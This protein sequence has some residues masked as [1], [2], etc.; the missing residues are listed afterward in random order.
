MQRHVN[1]ITPSKEESSIAEE[2]LTEPQNSTLEFAD[3]RPKIKQLKKLQE[4]INNSSRQ[5]T[6][7]Q[8][9]NKAQAYTNAKT[10]PVLQ[11]EN[12]T[13]LPTTLKTGIEQLSGFAMDDV[14]VHYNSSKPA[15][16]HAHAY[17][18]GS[19]IHMAPGQEKHLAHEAWHVVQQKQGRVRPTLQLKESV[20]IN[21]DTS[22]EQEADIMGAKALQIANN[23]S[24]SIQLRATATLGHTPTYQ[25]FKYIKKNDRV[26]KRDDSYRTRSGETEVTRDTFQKYLF[27]QITK[28]K[29]KSYAPTVMG[30]KRATDATALPP[31]REDLTSK[32]I[33]RGMSVNNIANN[34]KEDAP[35]FTV[36][37]PDGT[38]SPV[39]HIVH[40][41]PNSPYLSFESQGLNVSAGKYA[42]KPVDANNQPIGVQTLSSGFFKQEK[43]YTQEN[44]D[45]HQG[46]RIGLVAG[47]FNKAHYLDV[48]TQEKAQAEV[49]K[50]TSSLT[51]QATAVDLAVA[52]K[53]ILVT[54]GADGISK[55]NVPFY[56]KVEV[57]TKDEFIANIDKQTPTMALG[58]HN[59][60]YYK[61][62]IDLARS[63]AKFHFQFQID[64]NHTG[65][66]GA[67]S[68]IDDVVINKD[69]FGLT[70]E[71]QDMVRTELPEKTRE[72][73]ALD[74][75]I[76]SLDLSALKESA[77]EEFR[78][79]YNYL[80]NW[81][82]IQTESITAKQIQGVSGL[83]NFDKTLKS[84]LKTLDALSLLTNLPKKQKQ[85]NSCK[86]FLEK[87]LDAENTATIRTKF[88]AFKTQLTKLQGIYNT[89]KLSFETDRLPLITDLPAVVTFEET[90]TALQPLFETVEHLF[91]QIETPA[92]SS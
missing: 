63:N 85:L 21:D 47:I 9:Q 76:L 19:T 75:S 72:L 40:D 84:V 31:H 33:F 86:E 62:Q 81:F 44:M 52:D 45:R 15:Q 64:D 82:N 16:L 25:L 5:H 29:I 12:N 24:P 65:G 61:I 49:A 37:Q 6:L 41:A 46:K 39:E 83:K 90:L 92:I 11:K 70:L 66:G 2:Q 43:S 50:T 18:Q 54:P 3:R 17:A 55:G 53:E 26:Q 60:V 68:N 4:Q 38:A 69:L 30:T 56:A 74:H 80:W 88:N 28:N 14:K 58:F 7:L 78:A 57:L 22:L 89:T 79:D 77:L 10:Q 42:H 23:N 91:T 71:Q 27:D 67:I 35:I 8:F 32:L 34:A 51:D 59:G 20:N 13:G 48:S 73:S 36:D 1:K 87:C